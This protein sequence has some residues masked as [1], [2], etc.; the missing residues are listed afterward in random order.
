MFN[1]QLVTAFPVCLL[2]LETC[3]IYIIIPLSSTGIG[4]IFSS[5]RRIRNHKFSK[6][7]TLN[8]VL[9]IE[10]KTFRNFDP[11]KNVDKYAFFNFNQSFVFFKFDY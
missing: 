6:K 4:C 11:A 10:N 5:L 8:S 7:L 3:I 2:I 1:P 9:V